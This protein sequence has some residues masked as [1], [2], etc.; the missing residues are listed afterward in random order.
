MTESELS[1][2]ISA[3]KSYA[4]RVL[5]VEADHGIRAFLVAALKS[6]KQYRIYE[7]PTSKA[8]VQQL[9]SHPIDILI[10][11]RIVDTTWQSHDL[12]THLLRWLTVNL[13]KVKQCVFLLPGGL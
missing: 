1:P 9:R 6:Q 5:I 2:T 3:Q 12:T 10:L 8:V 11:G 7:A 4:P 13:R